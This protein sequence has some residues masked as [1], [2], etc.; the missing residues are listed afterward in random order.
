MSISS[1][2]DVA[3]R[4]SGLRNIV[5]NYK[6][7]GM[8][9]GAGG[10]LA[11][12]AAAAAGVSN[13]AMLAL[14]GGLGAGGGGLIGYGRDRERRAELEYN[15]EVESQQAA[16]DRSGN[17]LDDMLDQIGG[18]TPGNGD[19]ADPTPVIEGDPFEQPFPD[20]G[21]RGGTSDAALDAKRLLEE[22]EFQRNFGLGTAQEQQVAREQY[23]SELGDLLTQ[24]NERQFGEIRPEIYEDL[25]TRGLLRSSALGN[26][27]ASEQAKLEA[28]AQEQLALQGLQ[29]RKANLSDISGVNNQYLMG[30]QQALGRQ[31]SLED[32]ARQVSASKLLGEAMAPV[33]ATYNG[34]KN[35]AQTTQSLAS[36]AQAGAAFF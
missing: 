25:N 4:K 20:V 31:F 33:T 16:R 2:L 34:G 6:T 28:A 1:E 23:L 26:S 10:S 14:Y 8:G 13:P 19:S 5:E 17:E 24:R 29:D 12:L 18:R 30:R 9:A 36:L 21:A 32:Y 27:L 7:T 15:R 11:V 22:A 3:Y 35:S